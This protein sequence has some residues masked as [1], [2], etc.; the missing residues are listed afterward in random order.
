M[1]AA[2]Y[3][4]PFCSL[5]VGLLA[6]LMGRRFWV[7]FLLSLFLSPVLGIIILLIKGQ[8]TKDDI[9]NKTDHI[10]YC[11]H[12]NRTYSGTVGKN[13]PHCY[14][15][16]LETTVLLKDWRGFSASEKAAMKRAFAAGQQLRYYD[17]YVTTEY[18]PSVADEIRQYKK[19]MDEGAITPEEYEVKK[20]QLLGS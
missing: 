19:L 13:C 11:A 18:A 17:T 3:V 14:Q 16:T 4:W 1:E 10:F 20:N 15:P 5:V 9:L 12:C 8:V 2:A 6:S 7:Y